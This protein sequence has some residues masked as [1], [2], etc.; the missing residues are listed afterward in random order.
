MLSLIFIYQSNNAQGTKPQ[1]ANFALQYSTFMSSSVQTENNNI[2]ITGLLGDAFVKGGSSQNFRFSGDIY[3]TDHLVTDTDDISD[4]N[5]P[6][7]FELLQNY[8][9][10]FNPTTTIKFTLPEEGFVNLTVYNMLG[11]NVKKLVSEFRKAGYHEVQFNASNLSS[12]F[13]IYRIKSGKFT[14]TKKM[15]LIK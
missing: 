9:N 11:Q 13:Y 5:I 1:S 4:L 7:H 14:S 2:N 12:G 8:P 15:L 3:F 10:P 6:Q